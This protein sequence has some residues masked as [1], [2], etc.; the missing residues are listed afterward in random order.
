MVR[1][2]LCPAEKMSIPFGIAA[3]LRSTCAPRFGYLARSINVL[4]FRSLALV[5]AF[6][7]VLAMVSVA[8][9]AKPAASLLPATT[10]GYLSVPN[11]DELKKKFNESQLGQLAADPVMKPFI[12]DLK[13]QL[14][15]KMSQ[16]RVRLGLSM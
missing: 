6:A 8:Q 2:S 7:C 1:R 11:V 5:S 3:P 10:K 9:A 15:E 4:R 14:K 13:A 16:S 12:D